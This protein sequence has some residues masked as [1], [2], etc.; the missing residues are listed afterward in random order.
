MELRELCCC[1]FI[2]NMQPHVE[3]FILQ[4]SQN[5]VRCSFSSLERCWNSLY[6]YGCPRSPYVHCM[7]WRAQYRRWDLLRDMVRLIELDS[8]LTIFIYLFASEAK[9]LHLPS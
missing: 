2:R 3:G 7:P 5:L 4:Y 1:N 6:W 9:S 8:V